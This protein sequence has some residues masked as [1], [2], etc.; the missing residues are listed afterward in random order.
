MRRKPKIHD[1]QLDIFFI[2]S[3]VLQRVARLAESHLRDQFAAQAALLPQFSHFS[4]RKDLLTDAL[5]LGRL[6]GYVKGGPAFG[7]E[8]TDEGR[9]WLREIRRRDD[10]FC[11]SRYLRPEWRTR[12]WEVRGAIQPSALLPLAA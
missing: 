1:F 5:R 4:R 10:P 3:V 6:A 8:L 2:A 11:R 7:W 12:F 9:N